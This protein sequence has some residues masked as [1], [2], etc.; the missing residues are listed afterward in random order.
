MIG[1]AA[2]AAAAAWY[3]YFAAAGI[4]RLPEGWQWDARYV[5]TAGY[6]DEKTGKFPEKDDTTLYVRRMTAVAGATRGSVVRVRDDYAIYELGTAKKIWEY[7]TTA[8]V[9][10]RTGANIAKPGTYSVFPRFA[11]KRTYRLHSNYLNDV[12]LAYERETEI[13]GL[14]VGV[15]AYQGSVD[16]TDSYAG[17]AEF[18]GIKVEPGQ[19]IRCAENDFRFRVWV[20]RVSGAM[21]K[22]EES[23]RAGDHVFDKTTGRPLKAVLRWSGETEGEDVRRRAREARGTRLRILWLT[24]YGPAALG[25]FGALVLLAAAV[26]RGVRGRA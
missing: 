17:T 6:A 5:G 9:D 22:V 3:G 12:P 11:E 26:R 4:E 14:A 20:E 21:V 24:A 10:R 23:C 19:E 25:G 18:P 1:G 13:E 2:A 7:I 16:Y 8:E 15:Y